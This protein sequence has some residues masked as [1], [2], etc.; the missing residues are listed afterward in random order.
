M[1]GVRK[2][3]EEVEKAKE[4]KEVED[5]KEKEQEKWL[6]DEGLRHSPGGSGAPMCIWVR[7]R[8]VVLSSSLM[9]RVKFGSLRR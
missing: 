9:P 5:V 4:V 3:K 2:Q 8:K 6:A 1:K 7:S